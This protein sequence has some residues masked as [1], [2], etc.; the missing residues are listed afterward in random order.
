MADLY[1]RQ[2]ISLR[3]YSELYAWEHGLFD[4]LTNALAQYH[5]LPGRKW[6]LIQAMTGGVDG[7]R[8]LVHACLVRRYMDTCDTWKSSVRLVLSFIRDIA[9]NLVVDKEDLRSDDFRPDDALWDIVFVKL[10]L[11]QE[12]GWHSGMESLRWVTDRLNG[13]LIDLNWVALQ[14]ELSKEAV[15]ISAEIINHAKE[16]EGFF[17]EAETDS[18]RD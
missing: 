6:I 11:I 12:Y 17:E 3:R 7:R 16:N 13:A 10:A 2:P 5:K 14:N 18:D 15:K 1:T 9:R 8:S 4:P